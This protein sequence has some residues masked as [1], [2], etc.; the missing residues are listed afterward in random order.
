[1]ASLWC[2]RRSVSKRTHIS[3]FHV[4]V[5]TVDPKLLPTRESVSGGNMPGLEIQSSSLLPRLTCPFEHS[6]RYSTA[7]CLTGLACPPLG[8]TRD[9]N[10]P[11]R[12][13]RMA[14]IPHL[15]RAVNLC[16]R[17]G[18]NVGSLRRY[19][20]LNFPTRFPPTVSA[21]AM[22]CSVFVTTFRGQ[23]TAPKWPDA[24]GL[25]GR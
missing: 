11:V 16:F 18:L 14:S 24:G 19:P 1:M 6:A 9:V 17:L 22:I 15:I 13:T 3:P 23:K 4:L 12:V 8:R 10:Y 21:F 20:P 5:N 2:W 7:T 25:V